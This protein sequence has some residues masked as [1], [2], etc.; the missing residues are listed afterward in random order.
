MIIIVVPRCLSSGEEAD[1]MRSGS[2]V[3]VSLVSL[4]PPKNSEWALQNPEGKKPYMTPGSLKK[5]LQSL[6]LLK[7]F[8]VTI[9]KLNA[10]KKYQYLSITQLFKN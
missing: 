9:N 7:S 2:V 5:S 4:A 6:L 3:D 8:T 10:L 1:A